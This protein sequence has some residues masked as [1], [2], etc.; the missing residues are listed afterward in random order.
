MYRNLLL[1]F[2]EFVNVFT[3][4]I[5]AVTNMTHS[6]FLY[7][8]KIHQ[9]T[10]IKSRQKQNRFSHESNSHTQLMYSAHYNSNIGS[11]EAY[12]VFLVYIFKWKFQVPENKN[13]CWKQGWLSNWE[14][15]LRACTFLSGSYTLALPG[16]SPS[17]NPLPMTINPLLQ[18]Y[19]D[20]L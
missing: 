14:S 7:N 3:K 13:P 18:M 2:E 19:C 8:K 4:C 15:K 17:L 9:T 16:G 10:G 11:H 12:S 1:S 5:N 20:L 6:R